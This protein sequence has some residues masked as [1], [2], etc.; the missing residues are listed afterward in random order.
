M[1]FYKITSDEIKHHGI[2]GMHWGERNGPPYPLSREKHN[3]VVRSSKS[4]KRAERGKKLAR[5]GYTVRELKKDRNLG[6]TRSILGAATVGT[7]LS[8][9][10]GMWGLPL[11]APA[12]AAAVTGGAGLAFT[13]A[14]S[15]RKIKDLR[16]YNKTLG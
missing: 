1:I 2:D 5:E 4:E 8:L 11:A 16:E 12:I 9:V 7:A 14:N 10:S 3:K 13:A 6:Y 15:G